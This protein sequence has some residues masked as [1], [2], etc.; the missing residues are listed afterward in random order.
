MSTTS[1]DARRSR[2]ARSTSIPLTSG[3]RRST[4]ARSTATRPTTSMASAPPAQTMVSKPAS[5]P[6]RDVSWRMRGSSSAISSIG[7]LRS[8]G[9]LR[10]VLIRASCALG[11]TQPAGRPSSSTSRTFVSS[12]SGRE[13][14]A[15]KRR[16]RQWRCPCVPAGL[17]SYPDTKR[18]LTDGSTDEIHSPRAAPSRCGMTT[19]VTTRRTVAPVLVTERERLARRLRP[20]APCSPR[21]P[22]SPA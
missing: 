8:M 12:A 10:S 3:M 21:P 14:L 1:H 17:R 4:I 5:V 11:L 18:T 22:A 9:S 13:R 6:M 19:S 20:P 16:R 7:F 15:E 2:I